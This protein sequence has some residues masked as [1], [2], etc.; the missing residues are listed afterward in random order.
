MPI[1]TPDKASVAPVMNPVNARD[2]RNSS[3]LAASQISGR[4]SFQ[5]HLSARKTQRNR[6]CEASKYNA[7]ESTNSKKTKYQTGMLL[8]LVAGI[9]PSCVGGMS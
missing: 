7:G 6:T 8:R 3:K 4:A 2:S 1:M 9:K 5:P